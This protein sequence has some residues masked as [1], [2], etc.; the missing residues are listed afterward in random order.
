[1]ETS[2]VNLIKDIRARTLKLL[3][4]KVLKPKEK[5]D[6]LTLFIR[7]AGAKARRDLYTA[8]KMLSGAVLP[9]DFVDGRHIKI[10]CNILQM[11]VNEI[12]NKS[13]NP[14]N[15]TISLPPGSSK[16]V[17]CSQMLPAWALGRNSNWFILA[18]GHTQD[19]MID[20]SGR[21]AK[22]IMSSRQYKLLF[23]KTIIRED[24]AAAGRF[25]TTDNGM[26][27]CAGWTTNI[28]GRRATL[29]I[30]DDVVS[31]QTAASDSE[32]KKI[33]E[34]YGP[35][36]GSRLLSR[37]A[38]IQ[39]CT[40]WRP[41]DLIGFV[42]DSD[43]K[44]VK[45]KY[46]EVRFP[47][48]NNKVS[49]KILN[50]PENESFWPEL[51][52]TH[53]FLD[54]K[55]ELSPAKWQCLYLQNPVPEEGSY[56]KWEWMEPRWTEKSSPSCEY[57]ILSLDTAPT[58]NKSSDPTGYTVCGLY[59]REYRGYKDNREAEMVQMMILDG[60]ERRMDHLELLDFIDE[61]MDKY[62]V[63]IILIEETSGSQLLIQDLKRRGYPINGIKPT[64]GSG[65][66]ASKVDRMLIAQPS[67]R[68]GRIV[69]PATRW[70]D[71]CIAKLCQ[72]PHGATDDYC[73]A[74]SQLVNWVQRSYNLHT[75]NELDYDPFDEDNRP[76]KPATYWQSAG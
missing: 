74:T 15:P 54:K 4:A 46:L 1:M 50:L 70:A 3:K 64:G 72:F 28:S 57:V 47:A 13:F 55:D 29:A 48:L 32:M 68:N 44:R 16:S 53:V 24:V 19:F 51:W 60:G 20:N 75:D 45:K 35:G 61:H 41:D 27:I 43:K 21:K 62:S 39:L 76:T 34:W 59:R 14:I 67:F 5:K 23:P 73:D 11:T 26:F 42:L 36:L 63:D 49:S 37:A 33:R 69:F 17:V 52:P 31:E 40:R 25:Y 18:I 10:V 22:D 8:T 38:I 66:N 71:D 30:L 7:K 2:E 12:E 65:R 58:S 9:T 6:L 56:I